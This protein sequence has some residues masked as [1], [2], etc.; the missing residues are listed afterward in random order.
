ML[1]VKPVLKSVKFCLYISEK[2]VFFLQNV[3]SVRP[4]IDIPS[5]HIADRFATLNQRMTVCHS[6]VMVRRSTPVDFTVYQIL[7]IRRNIDRLTNC[8]SCSDW[9]GAGMAQHYSDRV[10]TGWSRDLGS[11]T[12]MLNTF[13]VPTALKHVR[14]HVALFQWI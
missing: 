10:W 2:S 4:A 8:E 13:F 7:S 1:P 14:S 3:F 5:L 11:I 6:H 9:S 12:G